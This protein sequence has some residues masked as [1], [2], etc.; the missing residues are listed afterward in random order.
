MSPFVGQ[1]ITPLWTSPLDFEQLYSHLV[2][3]YVLHTQLC[4]TNTYPSHTPPFTTFRHTHPSVT[5]HVTYTQITHTPVTCIRCDM[6]QPHPLT[7]PYHTPRRIF[8][9]LSHTHFLSRIPLS[10]GML[11]YTPCMHTYRCLLKQYLPATS[12][13]GGTKLYWKKIKHYKFFYHMQ[14][15]HH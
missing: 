2:E 11:A 12:F 14:C 1:L 7:H 9:T 5:P 3:M 8:L 15:A 10:K 4:Y 6:P 13:A